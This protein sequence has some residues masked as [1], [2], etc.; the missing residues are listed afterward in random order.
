MQLV[1]CVEVGFYKNRIQ[2]PPL[3]AVIV[4]VDYNK[5]L[6]VCQVYFALI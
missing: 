6:P 5:I 1:G 4:L 3:Y 2:K